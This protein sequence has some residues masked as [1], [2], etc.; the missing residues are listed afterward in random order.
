VLEGI[1]SKFRQRT[2]PFDLFGPPSIPVA[3]HDE[4]AFT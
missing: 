1:F 3:K 2:D 4:L